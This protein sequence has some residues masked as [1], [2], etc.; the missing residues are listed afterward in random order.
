[1]RSSTAESNKRVKPIAL[2][3]YQEATR[4]VRNGQIDPSLFDLF[5]F[6]RQTKNSKAVKTEEECRRELCQDAYS[7]ML[8]ALDVKEDYD[9]STLEGTK[10]I[11]DQVLNAFAFCHALEAG[12][13]V[14]FP[15][16]FYCKLTQNDTLENHT[17]IK[18]WTTNPNAL[19]WNIFEFPAIFFVVNLAGSHW[20][21]VSCD[22]TRR[23][24]TMYDSSGKESYRQDRQT[25]L[26]LIKQYLEEEYTRK[27]KLTSRWKTREAECAQQTDTNSCGV[28]VCRF[29]ELLLQGEENLSMDKCFGDFTIETMRSRVGKEIREHISSL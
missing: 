26:M 12:N 7:E 27:T 4:A 5:S 13:A 20:A 18:C 10:W 24:I 17:D 23:I 6:A 25:C 19:Y 2:N 9:L 1:M 14:V 3:S 15:S 22:V 21:L 11:N 8:K 16:E 29:I 28:F